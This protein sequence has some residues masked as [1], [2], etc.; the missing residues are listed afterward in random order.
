MPFDT[1]TMQLQIKTLFFFSH[2]DVIK[3]FFID[4]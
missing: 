3:I 4:E 2:V 1:S